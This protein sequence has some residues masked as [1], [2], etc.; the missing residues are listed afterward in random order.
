MT[1]CIFAISSLTYAMKGQQEL[2][3]RSIWSQIVKIDSKMTKKGCAYGIQ[4]ECS[5][6]NNVKNLFNKN[7]IPYSEILGG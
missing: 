3:N 7:N 1:R 6:L 4:I 5:N 2:N